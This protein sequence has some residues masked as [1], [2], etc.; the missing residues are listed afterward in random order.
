MFAQV[1]IICICFNR[2]TP[3][4]SITP[5]R[6]CV[7]EGGLLGIKEKETGRVYVKK[8]KKRDKDRERDIEGKKIL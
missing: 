1:C 6:R 5:L 8:E 3:S 2:S 4:K 7:W